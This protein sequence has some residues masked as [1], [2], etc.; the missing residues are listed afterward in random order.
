MKT[1]LIVG[2]SALALLVVWK[3]AQT[4]QA[5]SISTGTGTG[6]SLVPGSSGGG[7]ASYVPGAPTVTPGPTSSSSKAWSYTK[8]GAKIVF[9]PVYYPTVAVVDAYKAVTGWL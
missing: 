6:T 2:G 5:A 4:T 1:A 3:L 9:A 8:T 7:T